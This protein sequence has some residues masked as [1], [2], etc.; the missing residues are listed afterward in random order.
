MTMV[1]C[2]FPQGIE[3][4]AFISRAIHFVAYKDAAQFKGTDAI[5]VYSMSN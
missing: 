5:L 4:A 1:E 3:R 2:G